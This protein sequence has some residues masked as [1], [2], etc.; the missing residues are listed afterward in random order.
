MTE[1]RTSADL[2][3]TG[4]GL[5]VLRLGSDGY[6]AKVARL[7]S[8]PRT[9]YL[10]GSWEH[11]GPVIAIVG[12][13]E[14]TRDGLDFAAWLAG[15]LAASNAAVVSGLAHGIDAAAHRG[16]LRAGGRS[17]AVL[18][19]GL[20]RCY[21]RAHESLQ[22]ELGASLGLMSELPHGAAG[23]QGTFA[24][25]N[26]IL[27]ALSDVV[28]LVQGDEDSGALITAD[29]AR[30]V[31]VPVAAIPWDPREKL[32]AAPH[33]LIRNGAA[34]LVRDAA[35]VLA[36][37]GVAE[38]LLAAASSAGPPALVARPRPALPEVE[39]R[40]FAALRSRAQS[41]DEVA[42]RA[43]LSASATGA[44]LLSLELSGLARREPG[45]FFRRLGGG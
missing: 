25:R 38:P 32:A 22:R 43:G 30:R 8:P 2:R 39:S 16:A 21:P 12:A 27:A 23:R 15:N 18:G 35:D 41:L 24:A 19:T 5:R 6:P 14:A 42:E 3:S 36:L 20:G 34:T 33:K 10:A 29:H 37:A 44:A 45:G 1:P 13:R 9:L 11:D 40:A 17:G 31:G 26:R 7:A 28:V 4:T